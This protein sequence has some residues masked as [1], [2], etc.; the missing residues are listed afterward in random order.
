MKKTHVFLIACCLLGGLTWLRATSTETVKKVDAG[1]KL[2]RPVALTLLK[3]GRTLLI[4]NR[5]SGSVSLL[6]T[7]SRKV[8]SEVVV[9]RRLSDLYAQ[10]GKVA[11]TD[12]AAGELIVLDF[13]D[14][15][16]VEK[17]RIPIGLAPVSV[18]L[19]ETGDRAVVALL[20]P[21]RLAFVNLKSTTEPLRLL[22]LP[23]APRNQLRLPGTSKI[24]VADSFGSNL[25]IV[26]EK[27]R[28]IDRVYSIANVHNIRGLAL[29]TEKKHLILTHQRLHASG[30]PTRGEIQ[31]GNVIDNELRRLPLAD[32]LNPLVDPLRNDRVHPLG[33]ID[34]G[35][36]D[37]EG[38]AVAKD[39]RIVVLFAGVNEL[40]VGYPEKAT[41][42]RISVG[43]RPERLVVDAKR[44]LAY[45]ANKFGDSITI[46]DLTPD[47]VLAEVHLGRRPERLSAEERGEMDFYDAALSFDG[48]Y[49]C[50][51]CHTDGHT[52]GRLNDNLSDGS[53]GTPKRVLSLLGSGDT[54]PWAWNG[55]MKELESQI[56][57]SLTSTMLGSTPSQE[58]LDD[59]A[60]YLRTLK[61]PP[62]LL[63]ARGE[64]KADLVAKGKQVF[65]EQK[66][67]ACHKEPTYTTPRTYD[68]GI[69]DELGGTQFNPPSLRGVSQAGPYFHDGRARTLEDVFLRHR[70]PAGK[71]LPEADLQALLHFLGSL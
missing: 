61:T 64:L 5:D 44:N 56:K 49:S 4:A 27:T 42:T 67:S 54:G 47:T 63:K 52:N 57:Q 23:F 38:V 24:I 66:C 1:P 25:A 8:S 35:A 70:H 43:K 20:W 6:D 62:S 50:H 29:D 30:H 60:A 55:K 59:L 37:P 65:L 9:G 51:S 71:S 36:G 18:T 32:L 15:R 11:V 69:Q 14:H 13:A 2:R 22:D 21:R 31:S 68:V 53:F 33:D 17:R 7:E 46:V 40:A 58:R 34:R 10:A 39:G 19:D 3:D 41:W 12:E 16:L 45:V 28:K 26:D 48:W